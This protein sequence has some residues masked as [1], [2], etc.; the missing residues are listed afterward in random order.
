[1]RTDPATRVF[2]DIRINVVVAPSCSSVRWSTSWR[3]RG[4][5][6]DLRAGRP[7]GRPGSP[8]GAA[9]TS[10]VDDDGTKKQR[11]EL[12]ARTGRGVVRRHPAP[13]NPRASTPR[14]P[15][16]SRKR[17]GHPRRAALGR[18]EL[19]APPGA[20]IVTAREAPA[21][22]GL[23]VSRQTDC[24]PRAPCRTSGSRDRPSAGR[25]TTSER[26]TGHAEP[27]P[28]A[29]SDRTA[30]HRPGPSRLR[31]RLPT[32]RL[33][34]PAPT[35]RAPPCC[36]PPPR[37]PRACT[38]RRTS[39]TRAA[40]GRS[41]TPRAVAATASSRTRSSVL[42]NLDHR[43]AAGSEPTSGDGAGILIQVPDA[44]IRDESI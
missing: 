4:A 16:P 44:L 27:G 1:M 5:R 13:T 7:G 43:G 31:P 28:S 39:T 19:T 30:P 21:A 23:P 35:R 10:D 29:A 22:A 3:V 37:A 15:T 36:S 34:G 40:S 26:A 25:R 2:G 8:S 38:T 20:E 14:R 18:Q 33:P 17:G 12:P 11:I 32:D 42:H 6:E 9:G 24:H 41:R